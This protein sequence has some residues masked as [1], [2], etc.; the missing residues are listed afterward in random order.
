MR[1][2]ALLLPIMLSSVLTACGFELRSAAVLPP[3]FGKIY[4][5]A[6]STLRN[7]VEVFLQ[8]SNTELVSDRP[9]ATF[10]LTLSN[11]RYQR[12]VLSVDPDTGREREFEL[13]YSVDVV[14]TDTS[15]RAILQPQTLSQQR[16]YV[17]DAAALIGSSQEEAV[18]RVE[19]RRE[20]VRQVLY[21]LRAAAT[22]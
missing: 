18:L 9:Q 2:I 22:G 19:M 6:N 12:R 10:T 13:S 3:E 1:V 11:P 15:G 16:D 20:L 21:R 14:A 7:D 5:Q 4:V 17:F 8:G